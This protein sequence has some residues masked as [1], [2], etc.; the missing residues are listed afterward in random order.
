MLGAVLRMEITWRAK[1]IIA[2]VIGRVGRAGKHAASVSKGA[3][4]MRSVA[5]L[6]TALLL[7]GFLSA[8]GFEV[9]NVTGVVTDK[10]GNTLPGAVVQLEDT[11]SLSVRSYMTDK[12]GITSVN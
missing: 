9:R 10:R 5:F 8:A 2:S 7:V 12:N 1:C 4:V 11:F 6:T 3:E